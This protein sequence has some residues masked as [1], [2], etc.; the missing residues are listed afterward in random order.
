MPGCG[1]RRVHRA[2]TAARRSVPAAAGGQQV[3][4]AR[5]ACRGSSTTTAAPQEPGTRAV[6]FARQG[7][8]ASPAWPRPVPRAPMPARP[9]RQRASTA[10]LGGMA[11]PQGRRTRHAP[12]GVRR[13]TSAPPAP[14]L[15][16]LGLAARAPGAP[17]QACSRSC[18]GVPRA[19]ALRASSHWGTTRWAAPTPAR[20]QPRR[21]ARRGTIAQRACR[22]SARWGTFAPR[23]L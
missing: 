18:T 22:A 10:L 19:Q 11:P 5:S 15:P 17:L 3:G 23:L 4:P 7:T 14:C 21:C 1:A 16:R 12:G 13:G 9:A 8:S 20:A 6:R 2:A